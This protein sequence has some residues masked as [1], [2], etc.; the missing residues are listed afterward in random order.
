MI[1]V[2]ETSFA[3]QRVHA[4][5]DDLI[6]SYKV[7]LNRQNETLRMLC[8]KLLKQDEYITA[9][10]RITGD[11]GELIKELF[12]RHGGRDETHDDYR[13]LIKQLEE[14]IVQT[15]QLVMGHVTETSSRFEKVNERLDRMEADIEQLTLGIRNLRI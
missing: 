2:I 9:I 11:Y 13:Q 10:E 12:N 14:K 7:A 6:Y 4:R 15:R 5:I 1:P 8:R 3:E